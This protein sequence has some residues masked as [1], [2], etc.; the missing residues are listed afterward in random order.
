MPSLALAMDNGVA[1]TPPMGWRSWNVFKLAVDQDMVSGQ[2]DGLLEEIGGAKNLLEL[3][4]DT[5]GVDDGWQDCGA[6]RHGG[7]HDQDGK[8]LVNKTRFPDLA[9]LVANTHKRK[10]KLGWYMNNCWCDELVKMPWSLATGGDTQQDVVFLLDLGFD[11]VK[12]DGCGPEHDIAAWGNGLKD[13]NVVL[14]NCGDNDPYVP[15]RAHMEG[16]TWP[17]SPPL[18]QDV[19][20]CTFHMYRASDDIAP[21]FTSAMWNLQQLRPFL[22]KQKPLSRPGCWAYGDML[23]VFNGLNFTESRTHFGAWAVTS[24]PLTLAHDLRNTTATANAYPI[25]GN[26]MAIAVN[27]QWAGHPGF[28]VAEANETVTWQV[29]HGAS[30]ERGPTKWDAPVYQIWAKP[31]PNGQVAVLC[32]N[33]GPVARDITFDLAAVGITSEQAAVTNIWT[34]AADGVI[35]TSRKVTLEPRDSAFLLLKPRTETLAEVEKENLRLRSQVASAME[36]LI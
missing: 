3:G 7:F 32:I 13:G 27:Q 25:I 21:H 15:A 5:I 17:W 34:Q 30:N 26:A 10:V 12:V 23:Q 20:N 35:Q 29:L 19:E 22:D 8:P 14:E 33:L 24:S 1:K 11:A 36:Q 4:Y 9:G 2:V 28:L 31:Q 16:P 18:P 6:G